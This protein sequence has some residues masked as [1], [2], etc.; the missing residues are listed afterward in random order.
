MNKAVIP[1]KV[2]AGAPPGEIISLE[3]EG[4]EVVRSI[5][6]SLTLNQGTYC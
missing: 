6:F 4:N 5:S 1:V 3:G 2:E